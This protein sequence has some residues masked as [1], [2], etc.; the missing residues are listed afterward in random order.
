M[1]SEYNYEQYN[2]RLHVY[3]LVTPSIILRSDAIAILVYV[4][5]F[6]EVDLTME[7]PNDAFLSCALISVPCV[8]CAFLPPML[9][10]ATPRPQISHPVPFS[11]LG[12]ED[13]AFSLILCST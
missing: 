1:F 3:P 12:P 11:P 13:C 4:N 6:S 10:P 2:N 5:T 7:S 9:F 8:K